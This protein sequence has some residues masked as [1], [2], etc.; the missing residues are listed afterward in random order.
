MRDRRV[1]T[2]VVLGL[3]ATTGMLFA[4]SGLACASLGFDQAA[5]SVDFCFLFDCQNGAF[6]GLVK[7]CDPNNPEQSLL[8]DCPQ[9][10]P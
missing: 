5:A 9:T 6:G 2:L 1:R 3:V 7:F 8:A 10:T 4:G